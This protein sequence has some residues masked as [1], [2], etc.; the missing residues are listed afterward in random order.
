MSGQDRVT[1]EILRPAAGGE[2]LA[3]HDGRTV[4]V[5]GAIPGETV[6]AEITGESRRVLRARTV[7]VREASPH[8]V[9]DRRIALGVPGA[10]GLEFAHVALVHSRALKEQAAADQ[11]ERIGG[12]DA[13]Q[14][15][16]RVLP[17][18]LE[19]AAESASREGA[20]DTEGAPDR[21]GVL[22]GTAW[23]TRVQSAVDADGRL[24]MLAPGSHTVIPYDAG[25]IPLAVDE[26]NALG[27]T[28]L[29]LPG[30]TRV[31]VAAGHDSGAV[32]LRGGGAREQ[33]E[34]VVSQTR[35]WPGEWSILAEAGTRAR[36]RGARNRGGR[37]ARP[38]HTVQGDGWVRERVPG[39]DRDLRVRGDGFWQVHRDA[40]AVLVSS[41]RSAVG[42]PDGGTVLDLYCGA[43]L[44]GIGL[45]EQGHSIAGIEGS[46]QAVADA[47][48]NAR[49]LDARF[50]VGRVEGAPDFAAAR[51]AVLDPPRTG[52]GPAVVDAL[53]AS[54]VQRIVHVSC[55]G[56]TLAR[57]LKRL[58]AG[59]FRVSSVVAHDLFPVTGHL[60]FVAVLD[61]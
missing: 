26:V 12:L 51:T 39:V 7:E 44:L 1:L 22:D 3:H 29:R 25:I 30:V 46:A 60:E 50:D 58:V 56:A 17:A 28:D 18:P 34:A 16:F 6:D 55:D 4:F 11:L 61:R 48:A 14:V 53:L 31:E 43:G 42:D 24:G 49:G 19:A 37:F 40:A 59:G 5:A 32:V 52:A 38:L 41:V 9:T 35:D 45:A 57:D 15:G 10:G 47:V 36:G 27:L 23:R 20:P 33:A 54:S 2:S 13:S 21:E 8:R